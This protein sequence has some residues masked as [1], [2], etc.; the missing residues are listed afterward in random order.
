VVRKRFSTEKYP[1]EIY[2]SYYHRLFRPYCKF[3]LLSIHEK[4]A[5]RASFESKASV[6]Y[7]KDQVDEVSKIFI[8][9]GYCLSNEFRIGTISVHAKRI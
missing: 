6:S 8:I 7:R 4:S 5:N 9:P 1:G 2:I 3:F